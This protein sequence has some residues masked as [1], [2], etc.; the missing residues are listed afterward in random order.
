MAVLL[1][2][3][4]AV[5]AAGSAGWASIDQ[6]VTL[7]LDPSYA[8]NPTGTSHTVT[9]K[10]IDDTGPVADAPLVFYLGP[11][12][13]NSVTP[14]SKLT[15]VNGEATFTYTGENRG[16]DDIKVCYDVNGDG[17]CN[18]AAGEPGQ[19][20]PTI[21]IWVPGPA[22]RLVVRK[23]TNPSPDPTDTSFSFSAGGGLTPDSFSLK[24]GESHTF[25]NLV[26][27]AGY[28]L[29]E[30]TPS[31][32]DL[33]S[34]GCSD[35]SLVSNIDVGPGETVV[36]TFTNTSQPT[37]RVNKIC[38][39]ADDDGRF[40]LRI[41]GSVAGAGD[42]AACGGTTGFVQV[43]LGGHS[44]DETAGTGTDLGDYVA[45]TF[46]GDC[47]A[48]GAVSLGAGENKT[49][50]ITNTRKAT[51][52]VIKTASGVPP[53][54]SQ[55]FAFQL[56]QGASQISAGTILER[57]DANAGNGGVI[58]FATPLVPGATYQLCEI[59]MPGWMT[60]LGPPI[61]VVFHPS[62]DNSTVCTDFTVQ[63]GELK[64]FTINNIPPPGGLA[65]TIGF[66]K[67]WASCAGSGG[68]QRPILD[69]TLASAEPAGIQIGDLILHGSVSTPNVAPD[70]LEA[71]RI[72]NK[73]TINTG[74]KMSSDPAF[75]L[76][77]QLL[78]AKLNVVAGAGT[79]PA[80]VTAINDAQ[81]LLDLINFNG[82]THATMTTAQKNLA[83]SLA[84][85]LDSYNNNTIC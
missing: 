85:T 69:Q 50:T 22:S 14:E 33:T 7:T 74:R 19:L 63:P 77:A 45:P 59:V 9:A 47:D 18:E 21:K 71:V 52:Q 35:G 37:L 26:P 3:T 20:F 10:L 65:R 13:V 28:S 84:A 16:L 75:N 25:D 81:A 83:N 44:V 80:A 5:L 54:G 61:Y 57:Q 8:V 32:W 66:W 67:N 34:A 4:L 60:T 46:G 40:D 1:A 68:N 11:T 27:Q 64:T 73:S 31:S 15:D 29:A 62:G 58:N 51:A 41:D 72:L 56:R 48:T 38:Q 24:N 23:V 53:T 17:V 43:A 82:I 49:C 79:C 2:V 78:A 6:S 36:C 70:C 30:N 42:D 76:A 55:S 39:P 12:S